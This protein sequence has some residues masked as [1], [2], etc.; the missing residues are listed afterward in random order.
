MRIENI[1]RENFA[2]AAEIYRQGI[3]TG[4]ATFQ[5]EVPDWKSWNESHLP[6]C[7]IA[8][9]E[10]KNMLGWAALAPISKR[11]VYRGVAEVSVYIAR[12]FQGKG[13]GK[14]LLKALIEESET[15]G[16][17]T[18]QSSIFTENIASLILHE[19]CGF[20]KVGCREKIGQKNGVWKDN[21]LMER[22]SPT[23][24]L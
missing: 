7:R 1:N 24:G 8:A 17:W 3:E 14:Y 11:P 15:A 19:K 5:D 23:I 2:Q 21:I 10:D 6:F 4:F 12:D 16:I 22:R 18:L 9:F 20:R 13:L